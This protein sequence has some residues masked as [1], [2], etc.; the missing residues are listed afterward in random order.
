MMLCCS[1]YSRQLVG[2]S[3]YIVQSWCILDIAVVGSIGIYILGCSIM[4]FIPHTQ[5]HT[6]TCSKHTEPSNPLLEYNNSTH[7]HT[8]TRGQLMSAVHTWRC[9]QW[10]SEVPEIEEKLVCTAA[11]THTEGEKEKE[12]KVEITNSADAPLP[13]AELAFDRHGNHLNQLSG[14]LLSGCLGNGTFYIAKWRGVSCLVLSPSSKCV[15]V[16]V[17]RVCVCVYLFEV[18]VSL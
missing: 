17:C 7:T 11:N 10:P 15:C 8:H 12:R 1:I 3:R 5:T 9:L 2:L 13:T 4:T 6:H 18:P 14:V 16:C